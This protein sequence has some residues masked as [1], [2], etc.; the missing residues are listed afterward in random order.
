MIASVWQA[1]LLCGT[2]LYVFG[3]EDAGRRALGD[4]H[5]LDLEVRGGWLVRWLFGSVV[6]SVGLWLGWKKA[7]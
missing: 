1:V 2:K 7:S 5:C 3:G 6:K 4:L